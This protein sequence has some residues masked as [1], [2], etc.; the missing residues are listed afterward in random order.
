MEQIDRNHKK[1]S[2]LSEL[3]SCFMTPES[4]G[5]QLGRMTPNFDTSPSSVFL[6]PPCSQEKVWSPQFHSLDLDGLPKLTF[7]LED[8]DQER[9]TPRSLQRS[10][11]LPEDRIIGRLIGTKYMDFIS[12]LMAVN[13]NK[14]CQRIC[15]Y[16]EPLDLCRFASVCSKWRK[17]VKEDARIRQR[18]KEF[19]GERKEYCALKGKENYGALTTLKSVSDDDLTRLPLKSLNVNKHS[20]RSIDQVDKG[21]MT[22]V[23]PHPISS[24]TTI[25]LRPCPK[26]TSPSSLSKTQ[27]GHSQ[28][29]KC[30][31][32]FCSACLRD[33]DQH[34]NGNQCDGLPLVSSER[35]DQRQRSKKPGKDVVGSKKS[36]DRVRRL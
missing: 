8:G 14:I 32:R 7:E 29:Q 34:Q 17:F 23:C 28:C 36:K 20:T 10:P 35:T 30:G 22:P 18:W 25:Q 1:K 21:A 26:C 31:L 9:S 15:S 3:A 24:Q 33:S 16:L 13:C 2:Y 4:P 19:L 6:T 27:E 11:L 12:D 5:Y